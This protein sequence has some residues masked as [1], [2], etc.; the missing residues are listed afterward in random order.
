VVRRIISSK[1]Q[2]GFSLAVFL[3]FAVAL[4]AAVRYVDVNNANPSAPYASWAMAAATIQDAVDAADANDEIVVTNGV[5]AT[6]G[7]AVHS[8]MTNRVV[9]EKPLILRSVNGPQFTMIQGR[10]V[11]GT[12]NG[13]GAIRCI[14][15]TSGVSLLGFTLSNGA[16]L[17]NSSEELNS[18]G[19]IFCAGLSVI[20]NCVIS[21]NAAGASGGGA[22]YGTLNDCSL[23]GNTARWFGGGASQSRLIRCRII[24][25][26]AAAGGG[27]YGGWMDNCLIATNT[28]G[29]GG[30]VSAFIGIRGFP[31]YGFATNCTIVGN[32][33]GY[34]GGAWGST[35]MNCIVY[36]NSAPPD[37][38][39]GGGSDHAFSWL[40]SCCT[41]T[42]TKGSYFY[43]NVI[44]NEPMFVN[45]AAGDFRLQSNSPCINAGAN[46]FVGTS[47]DLDGRPRIFGE[48]VDLGAFEFYPSPAL[49][50]AQAGPN[51]I[52]GWPLWANDF[53]LQELVGS[54]ALA[55]WT[56]VAVQPEAS[57]DERF[58]TL[59]TNTANTFFRLY[60]P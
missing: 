1:F 30:G 51:I 55:T 53:V 7:R 31:Y 20:S 40:T 3:S 5:Y 54:L 25:N 9:V 46:S 18:G 19:G 42:N 28:A 52:L 11:P 24:G 10:Q 2:T 6:G 41:T 15:A 21:G 35:L 23:L 50:I 59:P 57:R 34:G 32:S 29:R 33:A 12:T 39:N 4:Q 44:T 27:L 38:N 36:F 56:K 49:R 16:T 26:S 14:Y 43:N 45:A 60:V 37:D 17:T 47:N 48:A 8:T 22:C 13:N 58:I